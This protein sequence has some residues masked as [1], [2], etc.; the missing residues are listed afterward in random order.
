M[1][2][3]FV[4]CMLLL[5]LF[6]ALGPAQ[7]GDT[8]AVLSPD[9]MAKLQGGYQC[10]SGDCATGD[11]LACS[12]SC[13]SAASGSHHV[14]LGVAAV[15]PTRELQRTASANATT[16]A[17]DFTMVP[18]SFRGTGWEEAVFTNEFLL[19]DFD[20]DKYVYCGSP[21][22][23]GRLPHAYFGAE[24][25]WQP[26]DESCAQDITEHLR[27][28]IEGQTVY[29][30]QWTH[31]NPGPCHLYMDGSA[32][33]FGE[34][35]SRDVLSAVMAAAGDKPVAAG[36]AYVSFTML[37]V[38]H[39]AV[40]PFTAEIPRFEGFYFLDQ[41]GEWQRASAYPDPTRP[42]YVIVHGWQNTRY[43]DFLW[44][45][46]MG[47]AIRRALGD[48]VSVGAWFWQKEA[49]SWPTPTG[50]RSNIKRE[51]AKLATALLNG[52]VGRGGLELRLIGHS[53]GGGVA[54]GAEL[55]LKRNLSPE[56]SPVLELLD[57]PEKWYAFP[58]GLTPTLE[59]LRPLPVGS[60]FTQFGRPYALPNVE[61][62]LVCT[63]GDHKAPV[64]AAIESG[65][66]AD[67]QPIEVVVEHYLYPDE[68]YYLGV[69]AFNRMLT[70]SVAGPN[71][72]RQWQY[73]SAD[74]THLV[75]ALAQRPALADHYVVSYT[76]ERIGER[77]YDVTGVNDDDAW[78][79]YPAEGSTITDTT[80]TITWAPADRSRGYALILQTEPGQTLW[81]EHFP[82]GTTSAPCGVT[83]TRGEA[84]V[85]YLHS[86]DAKGNQA[87]TTSHFQVEQAE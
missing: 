34:P 14:G 63:N 8:A 45:K 24:L 4:V 41:E 28:E 70:M 1:E 55:L 74:G 47:Q 18:Y 48:G 75:A 62:F 69:T 54:A 40:I 85:L 87:T 36:N 78:I 52:Y 50:A 79:S 39:S 80:P 17:F 51:A 6:L 20:F 77:I 76:G 15:R 43:P 81:S 44:V 68:Y 23:D 67:S 71:I 86:F 3:R 37:G 31:T 26:V 13:A 11:A 64:Y 19:S 72:T 56:A 60:H 29:D 7:R 66:V 12:G 57:V 16:E 82:T 83:L 2:R 27:V 25:T 9:D 58:L 30:S 73:S 65:I 59:A 53:Y 33:I 42:L 46:Q 21:V 84:Y 32:V 38:T 61:N 35:P 5:V 49:T 22:R 10:G